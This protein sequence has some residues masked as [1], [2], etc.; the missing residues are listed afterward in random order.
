MKAFFK[1]LFL[2]LLKIIV[3]IVKIFICLS[4]TLFVGY[5]A[6]IASVITSVNSQGFDWKILLYIIIS[7]Y[8]VLGIWLI[9]FIKTKKN[10]KI[11]YVVIFFIWL[12][13]P[14]IFHFISRQF[15]YNICTDIGICAEGL[16]FSDGVMS[17]EYCITKGKKW[18]EQNRSCDMRIESRTCEKQGYEW[19]I[20]EGK[21]SHEIIKNW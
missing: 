18:D 6:T 17:K 5:F 21:C 16:R 10:T 2:I 11:I 19:N 3:T 8:I 14:R 13:S 7:A 1:K 12:F 9:A 4:I 20:K 15:D